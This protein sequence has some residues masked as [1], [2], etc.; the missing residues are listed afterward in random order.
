MTTNKLHWT[1]HS[2][3]SATEKVDRM[4]TLFQMTNF[5]WKNPMIFMVF[6]LSLT[7]EISRLF[8]LLNKIVHRSGTTIRTKML[9]Y[10]FWFRCCFFFVFDARPEHNWQVYCTTS[11]ST[12]SLFTSIAEHFSIQQLNHTSWF[13]GV[14]S[15][16]IQKA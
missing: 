15:S 2:L 4:E 13:N 16:V 12:S 14:L 7:I 6:E 8:L 9:Q 5:A 3:F 10:S 1:S 11:I